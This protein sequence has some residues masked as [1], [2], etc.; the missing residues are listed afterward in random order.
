V[1]L[2]PRGQQP[3]VP[4]HGCRQPDRARLGLGRLGRGLPVAGRAADGARR[5]GP[6]RPARLHAPR[7][8]PQ[9]RLVARRKRVV[10]ATDRDPFTSINIVASTQTTTAQTRGPGQRQ[11]GGLGPAVLARRQDDRVPPR[12]WATRSCS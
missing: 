1:D 4:G 9:S 2:G 11:G 10:F 8:G 5:R 12:A 3:A 7:R 6:V